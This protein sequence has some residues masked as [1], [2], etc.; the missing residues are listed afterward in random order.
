MDHTYVFT[1]AWQ[2]PA[3]P[4]V[5]Y[6]RLERLDLYPQWWPQVRAA[7]RIDDDTC[8]VVVRSRLP[9]SLRV[10]AH[11]HEADQVTG[12]LH[13]RLSGDL[14][15]FVGWTLRAHADGT[16]AEFHEEVVATRALLRMLA[17][18]RPALHANHSAMMRAGERGLR[19]HL[20]SAT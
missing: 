16:R 6:A 14:I 1:G 9:Y 11:R 2:L 15:G 18:L 17:V 10:I 13:A 12:R 20:R 4:E 19:A 5:V 3:P 8:A 7:R